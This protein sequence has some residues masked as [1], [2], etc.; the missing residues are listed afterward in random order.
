[1]LNAQMLNILILNVQIINAQTLNIQIL[2]VQILNIQILNVQTLNILILNV[3][4]S[5]VS[6]SLA[7]RNMR[8]LMCVLGIQ[9][10]SHI[11]DSH[12]LMLS[13]SCH[14]KIED[15]RVMMD[16]HASKDIVAN[17]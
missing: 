3:Q 17:Q 5:M 1:M 8:F 14:D 12:I 13:R 6:H 4:I 15:R 9:L 16:S 11:P 7:K 10:D 2:N